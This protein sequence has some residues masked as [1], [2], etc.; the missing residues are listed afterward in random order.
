MLSIESR[1]AAEL[2]VAPQQVAAAVA[3]LDAGSTVPFIARYR[4]EATGGLD[5]SQL[6]TLEE[7]LGYIR[8]L[9]DRRAAILKSIGEQGKLTPQLQAS[10]DAADTKQRLEDLYLPYKPKRRTKAMIAREAG[11]DVL[12]AALL[13][14]P[15]LN[16]EETALTY[17]KPAFTT[18]EGDN[19]PGVADAKAALEGARQVLM[20]QFAEDAELVGALREHVK[21]QGQLISKVAEG[22]EEPGAKFRDYFDYREP[23]L[24]VPSHRALALFRGRKEEILQL[25][26]KLPEDLAAA[27]AANPTPSQAPF[28][29]CER[30]ICTRNHI[31]EQGRPADAWL[32]Q[33]ARWTWQVKLSWQI[34]GE[35]FAALREHA[36]EEAIRVFAR[37]LHDLLLAAPA[38]PRATMGLDPGL[39][40][41]VKVAIVDR[42]GKVLDTAT[43]Y[44]H[45]PRND[46]DGALHAL[47]LLAKTHNVDLISIGNGTASRETD[48]LAAELIK[49]HPELKL[50]KIVVSEAGAS[51][52]SASELAS[53]EFPNMDVSLRGAVSIARRLQD[54]LAELVKIDPKSIGVGQY[55]HDVSQTKLARSLDAVVED[56][57]NAVGVDVNTASP[58]LLARISGLSASLAEAMVRYRDEHGAF[59]NREALRKVPRLGEKTFEQAAGF[60]RIMG[61]DN[62]LDASAVHP[63]AYPLVEKILADT[64][65]PLTE[66]TG[67]A[68]ALES[69]D[70]ARYTSE[71]FGLPTVRDIL[72][73]LEKPGRDPRPQFKTAAFQEGVEELKDLTAGMLLEG[74]VTNVT[75]F[76]AFV[77]IGVHQDGLVHI[78]MMSHKFIKDPRELVKAGDVVKIKVLEVDLQRKR[79]ALTMKLDTPPAYGSGE[80]SGRDRQPQGAAGR[81]SSRDG[82][83]DS[84]NGGSGRD[85][86]GGPGGNRGAPGGNRNNQRGAAPA[87][88][89]QSNGAMAEAWAAALKGR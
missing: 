73:E 59:P 29:T 34:E 36:E 85:N 32:L 69:L 82:R 76:G 51:V 63:E 33:T 8:E 50:T 81:P 7:R 68:R 35:L 20:E 65:K 17:I 66:L 62:P 86:R 74:V 54:P 24:A 15:T 10:I 21:E 58:A 9:E 57:V 87:R 44:P 38:G 22:K 53:R 30:K 48:K 67:D 84:S 14:D 43:I 16:P 61:G 26:L 72:K 60:L 79:I 75:N 46:W 89:A 47:A 42:T 80:Q 18:A 64:G 12:A 52:Y 37:N 4:K 41:G 25:V 88:E 19:N 56:C 11:L 23:I 77:D 83:R 1:I 49:K 70:A 2:A 55:Q 6:R 71:Q 5:D 3:L 39:R 40:T 78:S 13:A 27:E 45:V 31:A 28:N